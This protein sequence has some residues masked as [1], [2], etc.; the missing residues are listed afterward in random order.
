MTPDSWA[1]ALIARGRAIGPIPRFGDAAWQR[2]EPS[3]PRAVAAVAVAAECW[4]Q[5]SDPARLAERLR[6]ALDVACSVEQAREAEEFAALVRVLAR[7]PTYAALCDR[8]GEPERAA[9]ARQRSAAWP[10]VA[11]LRRAEYAGEAQ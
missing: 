11:D 9:H 1:A 6:A 2:L 5:E 8:R 4:R 3:D 7:R 10:T